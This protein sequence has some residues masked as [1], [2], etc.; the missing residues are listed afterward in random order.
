MVPRPCRWAGMVCDMLR[1]YIHYYNRRYALTCTASGAALVSGMCC[2]PSGR[3]DTFQRGAGGI[4]AAC[5]V[6]VSAAVE[7]G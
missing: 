5:V 7:W 6:L 2:R 4:I 1:P 3:C